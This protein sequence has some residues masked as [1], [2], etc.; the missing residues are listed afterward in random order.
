MSPRRPSSTRRSSRSRPRRRTSSCPRSPSP[1]CPSSCTRLR[2]SAWSSRTM[3]GSSFMS[4]AQPSSR[5]P[6]LRRCATWCGRRAWSATRGTRTCT[7]ASS[8]TAPSPWAGPPAALITPRCPTPGSGSRRCGRR[9]GRRIT[10][11]WTCRRTSSATLPCPQTPRSSTTPRGSPSSPFS[12]ASPRETTFTTFEAMI[13]MLSRTYTE[14]SLWT[15]SREMAPTTMK[16]MRMRPTCTFA[17]KVS[18]RICMKG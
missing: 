3:S 5:R 11:T 14:T 9:R 2:R 13:M 4:S 12:R 6:R 8:C 15:A 17:H 18:A 7:S 1:S 16:V 10:R